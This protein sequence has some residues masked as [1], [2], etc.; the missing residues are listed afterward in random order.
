MPHVERHDFDGARHE[1]LHELPETTE[2]IWQH[3]SAFIDKI[4]FSYG[5]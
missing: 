2:E 5:D 3:V 1:L 4:C